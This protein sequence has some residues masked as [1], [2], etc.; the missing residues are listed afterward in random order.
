MS[1]LPRLLDRKMLG[2]ETGLKRAALDAIFRELPVTTLPNHR[3]VYVRR[4][5]VMALLEQRTFRN[6]GTAVRG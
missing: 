2:E 3:K 5:D 6:D 4:D 1:G